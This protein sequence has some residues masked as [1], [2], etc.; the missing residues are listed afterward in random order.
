[1]STTAVQSQS[2]Q[3]HAAKAQ[4]HE[5]PRVQ[6]DSYLGLS[7]FGNDHQQPKVKAYTS[8]YDDPQQNRPFGRVINYNG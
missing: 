8:T 3:R 5:K 7:L 2:T 1:M 4:H 6:P